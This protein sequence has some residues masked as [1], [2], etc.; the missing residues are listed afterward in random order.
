VLHDSL[1][2][3]LIADVTVG[4]Q[5][6]GGVDSSL[7][8]I[9][10]QQELKSDIVAYHCSV[11]DPEMNETAH[12]EAVAGRVGMQLRS[13]ELNSDVFMSD[14]F[15]R[16]TWHMDEPL[17]HP[18]TVGVHL[19]SQAARGEAKVLLSGEGADEI[20]AGYPRYSNSLR[21][22]TLRHWPIKQFIGWMPELNLPF[23]SGV[24]SS[25]EWLKLSMEDELISRTQFLRP[26]QI[27]RLLAMEDAAARS[28]SQRRCI[29]KGIAETEPL[30][31]HQLFDIL[32]Y[33][34]GLL[35]RQDK[36]SM[37]ASIENR[38]P[39]VTPA[40]LAIGLSLPERLRATW[41][42]QKIALKR[43]L[44]R[45]LPPEMSRRRKIGFGIPVQDW[46]RSPVGRERIHDLLGNASPAADYLDRNV[47][48]EVVKK[49]ESTGEESEA[50]WILLTFSLW[51]RLF[52]A[53]PGVLRYG[54]Q[55]R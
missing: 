3:H 27:M 6:S 9:M 34:P 52:S 23:Y 35:V 40:M 7:V 30:A 19:V 41:V 29:L 50:L 2:L 13:A 17:G 39:F 22:V 16:L 4:T 53:R 54:R 21:N 14:L 51:V 12:A 47:I 18:N 49:F 24:R 31:R 43:I 44:E 42:D 46:L 45:Y 38:V 28:E 15:D 55:E 8:A 36:M 25:A 26:E 32:T 33:L 37:A 1:K 5:F 10:V 20:F 11:R 48:Q